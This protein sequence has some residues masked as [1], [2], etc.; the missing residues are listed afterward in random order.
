[1]FVAVPTDL[2]DRFDAIVGRVEAD[3]G[4]G[5]YASAILFGL[6]QIPD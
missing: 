6:T 3:L 2:K 4:P 5:V 1:M